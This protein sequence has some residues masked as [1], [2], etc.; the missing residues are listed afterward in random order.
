MAIHWWS[1]D[2]LVT[3]LIHNRLSEDQS[4]RY[5]MISA[6]LLT[7]SLYYSYWLGA[8]RDWLLFTEFA[9]VCVISLI[10]LHECF[11]ANGGSD[12][13]DF[14]KRLYCLGVP[15]GIKFW[16]IGVVAALV[17]Y[18]GVPRIATAAS[19]RD[20]YL[21]YKLAALSFVGALTVCYYWR[22]AHHLARI[23]KPQR[24]THLMQP[25]GQERPV[26]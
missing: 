20:P 8:E 2:K 23:A 3:D 22:L 7:G 19:F 6:V 17:F 18:Y 11:K 21:V 10:G 4:L 15:L 25:T 1:T 26:G 9:A 5:A 16:L 13:S 12:G 24:S 14:L